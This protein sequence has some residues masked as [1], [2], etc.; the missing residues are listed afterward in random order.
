MP[1]SWR[2]AAAA[3]MMRGM[4]SR[5]T[6]TMQAAILTE[7]PH[8]VAV[9]LYRKACCVSDGS[10]KCCFIANTIMNH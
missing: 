4:T 5:M 1:P 9:C 2:A 7:R 10:W 3:T 8:A 6:P